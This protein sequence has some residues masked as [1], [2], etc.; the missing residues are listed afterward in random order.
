MAK[1]KK[2]KRKRKEKK[3]K[4]RNQRKKKRKIFHYKYDKIIFDVVFAFFFHLIERF[5]MIIIWRISTFN[6]NE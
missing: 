2:K 1:K 3:E 6:R 4:L 5:E